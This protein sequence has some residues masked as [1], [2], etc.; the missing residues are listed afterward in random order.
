MDWENYCHGSYAFQDNWEIYHCTAVVYLHR[1]F[2]TGN[3][4]E[5]SGA[6]FVLGQ[7]FF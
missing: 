3:T 7:I 4:C 2:G 1:S 6:W 5:I